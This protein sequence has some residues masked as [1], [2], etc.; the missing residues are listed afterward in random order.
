MAKGAKR[1]EKNKTW[2]KD[3]HQDYN[4]SVQIQQTSELFQA[5]KN[6]PAKLI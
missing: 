5:C 1:S 3:S 4:V 6:I 2:R